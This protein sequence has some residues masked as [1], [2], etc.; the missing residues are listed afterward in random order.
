[1]DARYKNVIIEHGIKS[2]LNQGMRGTVSLWTLRSKLYAILKMVSDSDTHLSKL[3]G[4]LEGFAIETSNDFKSKA[5]ND[6][7]SQTETTVGSNS[8]VVVLRDGDD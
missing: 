7:S 4:V 2:Y 3:D 6:Q 5:F 1:L 8:S